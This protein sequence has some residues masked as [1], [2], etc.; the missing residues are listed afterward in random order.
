MT[1]ARRGSHIGDHAVRRDAADLYAA[2]IGSQ[3]TGHA[4]QQRSFAA[5]Y[6]AGD[7]EDFAGPDVHVDA[8]EHV[9]ASVTPV[10]TGAER[11]PQS[12]ND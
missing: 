6:G 2:G 5:A 4:Q 1:G 12:A 8:V 3:E 9:R 7:A 10:D 11:F